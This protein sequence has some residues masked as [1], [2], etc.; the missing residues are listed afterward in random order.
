MRASVSWFAGCMER[1]L[2]IND[3]KVPWTETDP[4]YLMQR[5]LE[6]VLELNVAL[7]EWQRGSGQRGAVIMEA[8]DVANFAHMIADLVGGQFMDRGRS[9]G[10]WSQAE[11]ASRE[12]A[13][14]LHER[15]VADESPSVPT[16][17]PTDE[18]DR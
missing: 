1:K 4:G 10:L 14:S 17:P 3:H 16:V 18:T 12:Y 7:I 8:A 5:L 6:E 15:L 13:I 2:R 9:V 11:S